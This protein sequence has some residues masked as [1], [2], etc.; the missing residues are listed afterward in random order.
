[1]ISVALFCKYT[2]YLHACTT[3]S[4][5]FNIRKMAT[6]VNDTAL[7]ARIAGGD[8]VVVEAK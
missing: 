7:L 8:L 1:M 6:A 5:D 4:A 2:D 3:L